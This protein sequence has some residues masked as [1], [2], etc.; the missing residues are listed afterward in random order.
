MEK[1]EPLFHWDHFRKEVLQRFGV[2]KETV[3]LNNMDMSWINQYVEHIIK[4]RF[5]IT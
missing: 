3:T 4:I 5:Q 1:Q 2:D